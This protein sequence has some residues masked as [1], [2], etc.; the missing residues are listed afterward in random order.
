[1]SKWQGL[2]ASS[3]ALI[4][5]HAPVELLHALHAEHVAAVARRREGSGRG[6]KKKRGIKIERENRNVN[7]EQ[8]IA[9]ARAS[10]PASDTDALELSREAL[11]SLLMK[12]NAQTVS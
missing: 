4:L 8:R 10:V 11:T 5:E 9:A 12:L 2:G 3:V 7:D 6:R 1:M